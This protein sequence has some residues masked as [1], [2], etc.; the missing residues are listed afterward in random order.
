M[1]SITESVLR[2]SFC[3]VMETLSLLEWGSVQMKWASVRRTLFSPL[4]FLRQI[5]RSC[6]DS[7]A[8]IIHCCGGERNRSQLRQ[9]DT[10]ATSPCQRERGADR[11]M[12]ARTLLRDPLSYVHT[13]PYTTLSQFSAVRNADRCYARISETRDTEIGGVGHDWGSYTRVSFSDPPM[14]VGSS[15]PYHNL[16]TALGVRQ[17]RR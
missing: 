5:A 6:E 9:N 13:I 11:P 3:T 7:G 10:D 16:H 2:T 14:V 15:I 8:A 4:S 17:E 12:N 1:R